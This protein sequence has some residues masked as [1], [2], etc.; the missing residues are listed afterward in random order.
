MIQ[1]IFA[2]WDTKLES[3]SSPFLAPNKAAAARMLHDAARDPNSTIAK[4]PG[5]LSLYCLGKFDDANAK[6]DVPNPVNLGFVSSYLEP[7]GD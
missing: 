7:K 2:L 6:F 1:E 5:D 4:Y 3:Y